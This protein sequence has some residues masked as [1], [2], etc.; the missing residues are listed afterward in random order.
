MDAPVISSTFILTLLTTI[1]LGFFIRAS[2]K[3]RTKQI[4]LVAADSETILLSKLQEY[5]EGRAYRLVAVDSANQQVTFR[6]FVQPSWFL[7][8][9]LSLLA[10]FG[11]FCLVLVLFLLYPAS[12]N[13][14]WLLMGLAPAAGMFYWRKA[15]RWEQV[16][17]AI[18]PNSNNSSN[19]VTVT[20]HRDE[21]NQLQQNLP[22]LLVSSN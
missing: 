13:L 15:G 12:S 17:L 3:D 9:F 18:K 2:V 6:G 8:V 21:L 1:G 11:L 5:F 4:Q 19:L 20:A 14:L 16:L 7:A 22:S 10:A